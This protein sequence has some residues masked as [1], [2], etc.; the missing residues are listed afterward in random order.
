M[1]RNLAASALALALACSAATTA[2]SA[3]AAPPAIDD[4][5]KSAA[6]QLGQEGI[7][8]YEAGE[9][10][11]ALDKL[12]RADALVQLPSTGL[13]VA[14]TLAK[15]GKLVEASE[16]YLAVT[17]IDL[18]A[19][20][21][22]TQR[23]AKVQAEQE[24]AALAAR[25]PTLQIVLGSDLAGANVVLDG[26]PLPAALLGMKRPTNPGGHAI[27]AVVDG[28][29]A[30]AT[31]KLGEGESKRVVLERLDAAA[32]SPSAADDAPATE[33]S[34]AASQPPAREPTPEPASSA[35]IRPLRLGAYIGLGVG[36]GLA[37]VGA[38][39]GG[40]AMGDLDTLEAQGCTEGLCP[41]STKDALD[42]Y[43]GTRAASIGLL[44]GGLGLAALG[45]VSLFLDSGSDAST[46]AIVV[47][48]TP[49]GILVRG[50][51]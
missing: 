23:N 32:S 50:T 44:Y 30:T 47:Q 15:T 41:A 9:Y 40:T 45:G 11:A 33:A 19:D 7:A 5:T 31:V 51:F 2:V 46:T 38:I 10:D 36:G 27:V 49:E 8:H 24:R 12:S 39:L 48:P 26:R 37:L 42:S 20:A 6:R 34:P 1:T 3:W 13:L 35:S 28:R 25:I 17:K 4:A 14:R 18:P 22:E 21:N 29:R 16:K 43:M